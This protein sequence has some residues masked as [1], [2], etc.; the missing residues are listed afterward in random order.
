MH[1]GA[2]LDIAAVT[3]SA[4]QN[5]MHVAEMTLNRCKVAMAFVQGHAFPVWLEVCVIVAS[6]LYASTHVSTTYGGAC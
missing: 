4:M 6:W 5:M 2:D 1:P 3:F